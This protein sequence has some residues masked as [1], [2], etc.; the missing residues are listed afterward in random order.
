MKT[1]ADR[2]RFAV[3]FVSGKS[4][5]AVSDRAVAKLQDE[6]AVFLGYTRGGAEPPGGLAIMGTSEIVVS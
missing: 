4:P 2:V 5:M 6:L 1:D 3:R